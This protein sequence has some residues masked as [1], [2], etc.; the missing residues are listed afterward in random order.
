MPRTRQFTLRAR[1]P[2]DLYLRDAAAG[3][4]FEHGGGTAERRDHS[5]C[6]PD[7]Y[8][9]VAAQQEAG[10]HSRAT[11]TAPRGPAAEPPAHSPQGHAAKQVVAPT[12]VPERGQDFS[13]TPRRSRVPSRL[14]HGAGSKRP[15]TAMGFAVELEAGKTYRIDHEREQ[16]GGGASLDPYRP[17]SR[18]RTETSCLGQLRDRDGGV[19]HTADVHRARRGRHL[20]CGGRPSTATRRLHAVGQRDRDDPRP[21]PA[22]RA[23][24][25]SAARPWA[26]IRRPRCPTVR[27]RTEG[28]DLPIG[29]KG[30][31]TWRRHVDAPSLFG[32]RS[33]TDPHLRLSDHDSGSSTAAVLFTATETATHSRGGGG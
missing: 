27:G 3:A 30:A 23:C 21:T 1:T 18:M 11:A 25:S 6:R 12:N 33:R 4:A 32:I 31:A 16:P 15:A 19:N 24:R 20:P 2:R 29:L 17:A 28:Q 22:R 8:V 7:Y 14:R 5:C 13:A 9:R 26:R 10:T